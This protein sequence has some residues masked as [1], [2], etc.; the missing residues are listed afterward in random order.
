MMNLNLSQ[1]A[2]DYQRIAQAIQFLEEH[3][4]DQPGLDQI[5]SGVHLSKYHFQRLFKRWAGI[6][7]MQFLQYLTLDFTKQRLAEG[8]NLFDVS[9]DAGL[10]GP[11]RLHD[12][13]VTFE[14]IT[15]GEYKKKGE[16]IRIIFGFHPTPFGEC[17]IA[18]T[19]RGILHLSFVENWGKRE[20]AWSIT[21]R[22][23]FVVFRG[24]SAR[25]RAACRIHF[26]AAGATIQ[27]AVSS[28]LKGN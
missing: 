4:T 2:I 1:Q 23:V 27:S 17:L 14:A 8:Q 11:G 25:D 5:A 22:M 16:G 6:S 7:P 12:L 24:K 15:P 20:C 19:E 28:A 13:F 9:L 26:L 3:V 18:K 10:S 21:F